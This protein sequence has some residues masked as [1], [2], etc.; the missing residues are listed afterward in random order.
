MEHSVLENYLQCIRQKIR[1][2]GENYVYLETIKGSYA[3]F[4]ITA[5]L[6]NQNILHVLPDEESA[7]A[8]FNELSSLSA[9]KVLFFPALYQKDGTPHNYQEFN[10]QQRTEVQQYLSTK[11]EKLIVVSYFDAITES[12][13]SKDTFSRHQIL[14]HKNENVSYKFLIDLFNEY[15]FVKSEFVHVPG[16][17]AT[18]GSIVD[19]YSYA[20][21]YP[22]RI[23]F[24]N[25]WIERLTEFHP[26]TQISFREIDKVHISPKIEMDSTNVVSIIDYFTDDAI[27]VLKDSGLYDDEYAEVDIKRFSKENVFSKLYSSEV[28]RQIIEYGF[29][30]HHQQNKISI[31]ILSQPLFKKNY[32][33][34]VRHLYNQYQKGYKNIFVGTNRNQYKRLV[35]IIEEVLHE[36]NLPNATE[37]EGIITYLNGELYEGF[38]DHECKYGFYTE[39]LVFEKYHPVR[40]KD[41]AEETHVAL[42]IKDLIQLKPGDYVVHI[43][44]GIGRFAGLHT[45]EINGKKQEVIKL[46]Y[47]NNDTL[48]VNIHNLYRLSKYSSK[49]GHE[50]KI[51]QLGSQRWHNLKQKVKNSVKTLAYDLI[52][53]YAERKA[54][55][56]FA[57][58]KDTY[59]Q[60]ELEA[61]FPF[62][63]TPDQV[64]VTREVKRDMEAPYPMDR[65]VCGDVG[66]G[67]TEIAIRAA[68][69]AVADNKQVAVL[70][71]TTILAL[72]H[73]TTFSERLKDFPVKIDYLNRFRTT[74]EQKR[75]IDDLKQG[76]IDII[77][78]THKLLS[79]EIQFKDLGLLIIDEEHKFGVAD[80]D[81]IKLIKKEVDTL[82]LTATPIPRTLQF[83]LIGARDLS[84]IQTPPPNRYPIKT[85]LHTFSDEIIQSAIL[86]EVERGG[87][88]FF[89]HNK[90]QDIFQLADHIQQLVPHVKITVAHGQMRS[91]ELEDAVMSFINGESQ[92]LV[93]T[94]IVESGID[95]RNANTMIINNA[96]NFGLSDLHQ[97]RGRV[98]RTNKQAYCYLLVPSLQILTNDA[99][100]R[101]K[102]IVEFSDLGSG[103]QIA[104]K[105]LDIRGAGNLLGA[106]QSGFINEMGID[107]YMKI[108]NEAISEI[109]QQEE[110]QSEKIGV[111]SHR[112]VAD[113]VID[114]DWPLF[115]PPDY[116][117]NASERLNLYQQLNSCTTHQQLDDFTN[118]LKDR[119]G[120]IPKETDELIQSVRLR[121]KAS[122][123]GF[124]KLILKGDKMIAVFIS[125][126]DHVFYK[127]AMFQRIISFISSQKNYCQVR[128]Q[129]NKLMLVFENVKDVHRAYN[130]VHHL[131]DQVKAEDLQ[132]NV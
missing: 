126:P 20:H 42:T 12:V 93:S 63:D 98:G 11:T 36:N 21:E 62:E 127:T 74:R 46:L 130:I 15:G 104:M 51:D 115:I 122:H 123:L 27:F 90:V 25:N 114:T 117:S 2:E 22:V 132:R 66:F 78:G 55:K 31:N 91:N 124:E 103:F 28:K 9:N 106:E 35:Q 33:D 94:N 88:V 8:S 59:L 85:E 18:R 67:K 96:Q 61:S 23:E 58:S 14:L 26:S 45:I 4:L 69:K 19:V 87:Q 44:H 128:E 82:V 39:Y 107:T 76:K 83:S 86:K 29:S 125:N 17:Y 118:M 52:R 120:D 60:H 101:L 57:F 50:P 13:P 71:P 41:K 108:L 7:L 77:I 65:L 48:F 49:D 47:K 43:D 53:L 75:I 99:K 32:G 102:V 37:S 73:Y 89:I 16:Q 131:Y 95:I 121:W 112:F 70:V 116:V 6:K 81:K 92:V 79:K 38:I 110:D 1:F 54:S 80:K 3:S 10:L 97:L 111:F 119:F 100:K 68:F 84:V 105:D 72:Q 113:T 56:G 40:R 109:K 30:Q 24:K 34:F 64:K 5:L 129:N